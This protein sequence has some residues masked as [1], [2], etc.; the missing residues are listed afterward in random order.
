MQIHENDVTFLGHDENGNWVNRFVLGAAQ[1]QNIEVSSYCLAPFNRSDAHK[2][3]EL[4]E[5]CSWFRMQE[6]SVEGLK[7]VACEPP[8][9]D[10]PQRAT[11]T[12]SRSDPRFAGEW[13][14]IATDNSSGLMSQLWD[15]KSLA[16]RRP[17]S[18]R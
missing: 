3:E 16:F 9:A 14:D 8:S 10:L 17:L 7:Q 13:R 5:G 2:P 1:K 4:K 18:V 15:L 6:F 11:R 12:A